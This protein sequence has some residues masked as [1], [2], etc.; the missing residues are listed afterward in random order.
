MKDALRVHREWVCVR[1]F[2]VNKRHLHVNVFTLS[3]PLT[4]HVRFTCKSIHVKLELLSLAMSCSG[5]PRCVSL[6]EH[7]FRADLILTCKHGVMD[8]CYPVWLCI[9]LC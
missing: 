7:L 2:Y 8:G 6:V 1:R 3:Q 9:V 4:S 5:D